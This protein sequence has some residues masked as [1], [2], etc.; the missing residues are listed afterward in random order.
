MDLVVVLGLRPGEELPWQ[1]VQDANVRGLLQQPSRRTTTIYVRI[2]DY[3]ENWHLK[4]SCALPFRIQECTSSDI[5]SGTF[6]NN[7]GAYDVLKSCQFPEIDAD[8][9]E[10]TMVRDDGLLQSEIQFPSRG[11]P[12][13]GNLGFCNVSRAGFCWFRPDFGQTLQAI[14]T[15]DSHQALWHR[16]LLG[17]RHLRTCKLLRPDGHRSQT[18]RD[19][20]FHGRGD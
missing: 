3:Q 7:A 6:S 2:G 14:H 11:A 20:Y 19:G 18:G 1:C 13:S 17:A 16:P 4:A 8:V 10:A 15:R 9:A 5:S 12:T